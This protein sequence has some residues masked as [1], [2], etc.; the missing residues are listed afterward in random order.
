MKNYTVSATAAPPTGQGG[1]VALRRWCESAGVSEIT[2]WR[3]RKLGWLRTINI[4][5]R[6]YLAA[7]EIERF[8]QRAQAGEF[9]SE[10]TVP[11]PPTKPE[12]AR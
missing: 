1:L 3:W 5:G 9:A 11:E 12:A 10:H 4:S 7:D 8:T 2:A 6:V